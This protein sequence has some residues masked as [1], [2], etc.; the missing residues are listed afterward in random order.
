MASEIQIKKIYQLDPLVSFNDT[1]LFVVHQG[2]SGPGKKTR[3]ATYKQLLDAFIAAISVTT[4]L[5]ELRN[6]G[7]YIQWK[8]ASSNTWT[9]LVALAD[10]TGADG[11]E[12]EMRST[13]LMLQW[14]YVGDANWID[15]LD[16]STL[17]GTPGAS[18]YEIALTHGF[19]GTEQEW[20]DSLKANAV[21]DRLTSPDSSKVVTL[22]NSGNVNLPSGGTVKSSSG[23]SVVF[24]NQAINGGTY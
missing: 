22:D 18:A 24:D 2:G 8:Y 12:V 9:N 20:L 1:D 7:T 17:Q 23:S 21:T 5:V 10:I 13:N 3:K 15:L 6:N 19:V 11:R 16:L 4:D 14:R